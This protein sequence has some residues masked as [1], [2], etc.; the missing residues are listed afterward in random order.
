[1]FRLVVWQHKRFPSLVIT[2]ISI[3]HAKPGLPCLQQ[4]VFRKLWIL[5]VL[6]TL[7]LFAQECLSC[8]SSMVSVPRTKFR[9]LNILKQLISQ[10][11][12]IMM[13][14]KNS[15]N[16]LSILSILLPAVQLRTLIFISRAAKQLIFSMMQFLILL[17]I[18]CSKSARR[19][20]ANTI[21]LLIMVQQMPKTLLWQWDQLPKL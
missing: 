20:V 2:A 5:Q 12:W 11:F 6:L 3:P 15:A 7:Q 17:K 18:T 16:V 14:L 13:R 21:R 1:M 9:K 10:N 8:T 19:L 4:E